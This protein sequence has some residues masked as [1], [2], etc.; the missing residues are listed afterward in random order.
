MESLPSLFKPYLINYETTLSGTKMVRLCFV[1]VN[2][3]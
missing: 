3:I 1:S 2:V